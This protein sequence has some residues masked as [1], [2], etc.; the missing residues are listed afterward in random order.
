MPCGNR[1]RDAVLRKENIIMTKNEIARVV[2]AKT[3]LTVKDSE[4]AV[5]ALFEAIV[6]TLAIGEKVTI[7]G[8]GTF[9]VRERP[10]HEGFNPITK[11][12]ITIKASKTPALKPAKAF[13]E[14]LSDKTEE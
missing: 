13:K 8:F 5:S 2:A 7:A 4:K 11:E 6:E 9:D 12:K 14:A 3:D 1:R 10:E